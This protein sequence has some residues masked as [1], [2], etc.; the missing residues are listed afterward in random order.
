MTKCK[1]CGHDLCVGEEAHLFGKYRCRQP[2]DVDIIKKKIVKTYRCG[3]TNLE[4]ETI[5][6][7]Q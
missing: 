4:P 1:N 7:S 3:C 6:V 5:E 2:I